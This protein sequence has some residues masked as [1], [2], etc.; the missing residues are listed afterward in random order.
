MAGIDELNNEIA[1]KKKNIVINGFL[2]LRSSKITALP[3]GLTVRGNFYLTNTAITALPENLTVNGSLYISGTAITILPDT[4][5]VFGSVNLNGTGITAL[6][7]K[8]AIGG[9]V[10]GLEENQKRINGV[11]ASD[12]EA[13]S[14]QALMRQCLE[15]VKQEWEVF[16]NIC[17]QDK[18]ST[19]LKDRPVPLVFM[20]EKFSGVVRECVGE[21]YSSILSSPESFWGMVFSAVSESKTCSEDDVR[22]ALKEIAMK[23]AA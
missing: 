20:I 9:K 13:A 15:K 12:K 6:P 2:D 23:H 19:L 18:N 16:Y 11:K 10:Y 7:D 21:K 8:P 3:D 22:A 17:L 4:L 14:A 1:K 5:T